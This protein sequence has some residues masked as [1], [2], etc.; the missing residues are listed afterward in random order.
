LSTLST[1]ELIA[2]QVLTEGMATQQPYK[3]IY[4]TMKKALDGFVV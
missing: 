3:E 4:Q 2:A 1:I